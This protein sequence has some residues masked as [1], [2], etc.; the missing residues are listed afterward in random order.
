MEIVASQ[1]AKP[2]KRFGFG[3]KLEKPKDIAE[4]YEEAT[5]DVVKRDAPYPAAV[6]LVTLPLEDLYYPPAVYGP[7]PV[8]HVDAPYPAPVKVVLAPYPAT[9]PHDTIDCPFDGK[10]TDDVSNRNWN[11]AETKHSIAHHI[12]HKTDAPFPALVPVVV[13]PPPVPVE[14]VYAPYPPA[15]VHEVYGPPPVPHF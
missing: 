3:K 7:P 14:A 8:V 9:V 2:I 1:T 4:K 12:L 10:W 6:P 5:H 11:E 13:A 15:V